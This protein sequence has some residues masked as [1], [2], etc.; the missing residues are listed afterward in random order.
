ME[1]TLP[2]APKGLCFDRND[3]VKV[4]TVISKKLLY[5]HSLFALEIFV[6]LIIMISDEF[7]RG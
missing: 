3:F 1:F 7:F 4:F 6:I 2:P 5:V